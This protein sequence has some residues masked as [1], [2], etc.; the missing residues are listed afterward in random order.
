V[1]VPEG[2]WARGRAAFDEELRAAGGYL[3]DQASF[4]ARVRLR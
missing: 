4:V 2:D 1:L 3:L